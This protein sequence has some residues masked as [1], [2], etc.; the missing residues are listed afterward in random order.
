[1]LLALH[2]F[3]WG[4]VAG[5]DASVPRLLPRYSQTYFFEA[6]II[7][8]AVVHWITVNVACNV[9]GPRGLSAEPSVPQQ[10]P[11][12]VHEGSETLNAH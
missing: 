8:S 9:S 2:L 12:T 4:P 1:M 5:L 10:A 11:K 3:R 7:A 6:S